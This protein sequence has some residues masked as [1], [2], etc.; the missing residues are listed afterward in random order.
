MGAYL[1]VNEVYRRHV[2][3]EEIGTEIISIRPD[4][5]SPTVDLY[6][7]KIVLIQKLRC[8]ALAEEWLQIDNLDCLILKS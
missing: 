6:L 3:I 1:R 5:T 8:N 2:F 4:D 7:T